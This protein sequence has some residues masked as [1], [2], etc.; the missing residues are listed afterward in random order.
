MLTKNVLPDL[1]KLNT[2]IKK[3]PMDLMN[4]VMKKLMKYF[5]LDV[6]DQ[7]D[8]IKNILPLLKNFYKGKLNIKEFN[9]E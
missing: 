3:Y 6:T 4:K 7:N 2:P 9:L 8:F 1:Y 5:I